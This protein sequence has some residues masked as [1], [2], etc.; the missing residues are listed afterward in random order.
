MAALPRGPGFQSMLKEGSKYLEGADDV[1]NRNIDACV[2]LAKLTSTGYG[3]FGLSKFVINHL[4]K[5][6]VTSDASTILSEAEVDQPAARILAQACQQMAKEVGDG[7]NFV[8]LFAA[9]LLQR[10]RPNLLRMGVRPAQIMAGFE[11]AYQKA[12]EE[13]DNIVVDEIKDLSEVDK[14][15]NVL[16]SVMSAKQVGSVPRLSRLLAEACVDASNA[17]LHRNDGSSTFLDVDNVR[18]CKILGGSVDQSFIVRGMVLKSDVEGDIK[19]L[20]SSDGSNNLRVAM[21]SCPV[22]IAVLETKGTVLM[23]NAEELL[24]F[25]KGEESRLYNQ[26]KAIAQTGVQVIVSGTK[27]SEMAIHFCNQ[28]GMVAVKCISKFDLRRVSRLTR[29]FVHPTLIVPK[30]HEIGFC[31]K[32]AVSELGRTAITLIETSLSESELRVNEIMT[33]V[34]RV[35][36]AGAFEIEMVCRINQYATTINQGLDRFIIQCFAES[37]DLMPRILA[38]NAGFNGTEILAQLYNAHQ[39][40]GINDAG[41]EFGD[42]SQKPKVVSVKDMAPFSVYDPLHVKKWALKHGYMAA[43]T[44]LGVD[45]LLAAKPAGGPKLKGSSGWDED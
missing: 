7:T 12:L 14:V 9:S 10:S 39:H 19:S 22:D 35:A 44:V 6:Q 40:A 18:I 20:V 34:L 16:R 29:A 26:L 31:S 37:F 13:M 17:R 28:L 45:R 1:L 5:L 33:V 23:T 15:S 42:G 32:V 27:F 25:S 21:Y 8:L 3:P 24:S 30:P 38:D 43:I 36:G 41:I 11:L 2:L 4:D